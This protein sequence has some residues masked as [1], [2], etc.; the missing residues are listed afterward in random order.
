MS[1][2]VEGKIYKGRKA[3]LISGI[4]AVIKIIFFMFIV[5]FCI[6]VLLNGILPVVRRT[7]GITFIFG[8]V[9]YFAV[10][11]LVAIPCM[12]HYVYNAFSYCTYIYLVISLLLALA[13]IVKAVYLLRKH[14]MDYLTLFPG[15]THATAHELL[16]PRSDPRMLKLSYSV[17]SR[18]YWGIFFT[19]LLVQMI[20]AVVMSS[21]DGD[22][23]YYVVESLLAQQADVMNTILPYT[24]TSTSL[25]I[26]HALAVITMWIAYMARICGV[27]ATIMSHSVVPVLIIPLVYLVYVEIARI[28]FRRRQEVIPVFMIIVS[29]L[30]M[31]GNISIYTPATF[32]LTRTW[33]G[34]AIVNSLVFP[35][36]MW[37]FLWMLEDSRKRP[38][39]GPKV[40]NSTESYEEYK[41][42]KTIYKISPW[43]FLTLIN[44]LSGVCTSMGVIFGTGLVAL[45]TLVLLL[46]ERN[47]RVVIGAIC[48]VIPNALYLLVYL[49]LFHS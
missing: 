1:K 36:I 16:S 10:F 7:V 48:C 32:F 47:L 17:E 30:M 38:I 24:G 2:H 43:I 27:H 18:I 34:K 49:G 9:V 33:Q 5:P 29:F 23:A 35:L 20:L 4:L 21:F 41:E 39:F 26:R 15:E 28:L 37:V 8:Y 46:F 40:D 13:G 3:D 6:G 22:D 19:L 25:D 11:E 12:L 42:H 45:F 31:F 14:G 44:M